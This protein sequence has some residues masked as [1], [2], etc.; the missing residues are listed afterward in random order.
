MKNWNVST[1]YHLFITRFK[2]S[3]DKVDLSF[4]SSQAAVC[5]S[6]YIFV[7]LMLTIKYDFAKVGLI[8]SKTRIC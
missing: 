3:E 7:P 1:F 6:K 8:E 5:L 4:E 2:R